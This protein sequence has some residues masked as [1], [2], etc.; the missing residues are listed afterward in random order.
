MVCVIKTNITGG[1]RKFT[2]TLRKVTG[3]AATPCAVLGLTKLLKQP[4]EVVQEEQDNN[5]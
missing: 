5:D 3:E 1:V 4:E 2:D